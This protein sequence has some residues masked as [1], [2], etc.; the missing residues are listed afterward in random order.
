MQKPF[1]VVYTAQPPRAQAQ[2]KKGEGANR[3]YQHK[4]SVCEATMLNDKNQSL[5]ECLRQCLACGG[6]SRSIF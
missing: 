1:L 4:Y 3:K 2:R 5:T 6:C